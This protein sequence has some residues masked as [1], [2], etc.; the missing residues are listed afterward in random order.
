[1]LCQQSCFGSLALSIILEVNPSGVTQYNQLKLLVKLG[2][3]SLARIEEPFNSLAIFVCHLSSN[4]FQP[5]LLCLHPRKIQAVL[6]LT[7]PRWGHCLRRSLAMR[8]MRTLGLR[9]GHRKTRMLPLVLASWARI[10]S[11]R[12]TTSRKVG[13]EEVGG[14]G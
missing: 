3:T 6:L 2:I 14:S 5:L 1:M 4:C 13:Q 12:P 10:S 9:P 11:C 8:W 7:T